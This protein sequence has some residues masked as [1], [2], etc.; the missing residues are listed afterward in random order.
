MFLEIEGLT[1]TWGGDPHIFH[2]LNFEEVYN[3]TVS[4]VQYAMKTLIGDCPFASGC[5]LRGGGLTYRIYNNW[6]KPV[7]YFD[8]SSDEPRSL[9][10]TYNPTYK[11]APIP[12]SERQIPT[13]KQGITR[14]YSN[15]VRNPW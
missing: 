3:G 1:S 11:V 6:G 9:Y 8:G 10:E 12:W 5:Y 13:N 7:E 14:H 2:V 4:H 15:V